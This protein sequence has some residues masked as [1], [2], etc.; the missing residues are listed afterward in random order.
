[1]HG[2]YKMYFLIADPGVDM[3]NAFFLDSN[4]TLAE[5]DEVQICIMA[6]GFIDSFE[7]ILL[8]QNARF[9]TASKSSSSYIAGNGFDQSFNI[10]SSI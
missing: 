4:L 3:V 6:T 1:M 10:P 8:L 2:I 9:L 7:S 5:G